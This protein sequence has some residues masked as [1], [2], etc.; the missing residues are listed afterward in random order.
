MV[1]DKEAWCAVVH[2]VTKSHTTEWLNNRWA[3]QMVPVVKSLPDNAGDFRDTGWILG[4]GR[5]PEGENGTPLQ[6]SFWRIS[7]TEEP[8]GLQSTVSQ[9]VGLQW[10]STAQHIDTLKGISL[11]KYGDEVRWC[12]ICKLETQESQWCSFEAWKIG[13]GWWRVQLGFEGW[14]PEWLR[15]REDQ[16]HSLQSGRQ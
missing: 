16:Y 2:G 7:W 6:Y 5:S 8:G 13:S 4:S 12:T 11:Y 9:R 15:A 10:L 1:K 14:K 3:S